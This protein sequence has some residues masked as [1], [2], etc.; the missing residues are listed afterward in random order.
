MSNSLSQPQKKLFQILSGMIPKP[1]RIFLHTDSNVCKY[2]DGYLSVCN[3]VAPASL[4]V[5]EAGEKSK[6]LSTVAAV[7]KLLMEG[8]ATRSSV[9]VNLGGGVVS[10]LGGFVASIF[11]RGMRTV[12]VATTLLAAADAAIG[13]KTGVDFNELKNELG[14]FHMPEGVVV[15]TDLLE[16][17]PQKVK[18]DGY[19]E[20]LK[21]AML[22]D[23][24]L[25]VRLLNVPEMLMDIDAL[26]KAAENCAKFKQM[27][28]E[29]DPKEKGRRR[30]LNLGHTFGHAFETLSM[31]KG[32]PCGHGTAVAHG[33]LCTLI[34][35]RLTQG[36]D[37]VDVNIYRQMLSENYPRLSVACNDA[38]RI[39][40]IIRHDKKRD[41][42]G[43]PIFVLLRS[44]GEP[45]ESFAAEKSIIRA[46][47]EC[48]L[49]SL[50]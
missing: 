20:M 7:A 38:D 12:N 21:T 24:Q 43:N 11:K 4:I 37:A 29:I 16:F 6:N 13:G 35:S 2:A 36:F 22:F 49:D 50:F 26:G 10:D 14:T 9:M 18:I 1:D 44:I 5:N 39:V 32:N 17:Q 19:A 45:I 31:L 42:Q 8:G 15:A 23:R 25:Y 3:D 46:T 30:I 47:L 27:I 48:Y 33:L 34:M 40:D 28:V 41:S